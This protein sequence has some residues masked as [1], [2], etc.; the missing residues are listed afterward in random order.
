M[1][2][3]SPML[4]V[5]IFLCLEGGTCRDLIRYYHMAIVFTK[6]KKNQRNLIIVFILVM[7]VTF[8]VI[9][10]GF[11]KEGGTIFPEEPFLPPQKE[12]KINF[13]ILDH[14]ALKEFEPFVEIEPFQEIPP[15]QGQPEKKIG[16]ENPFIPY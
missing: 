6:Q 14:P 4:Y 15:V 7:I 2:V 13:E 3:P 12:I 16:R 1:L 5:L 8:L 11:F 10:Q 9:W